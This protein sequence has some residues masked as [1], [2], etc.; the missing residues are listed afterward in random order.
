MLTGFAILLNVPDVSEYNSSMMLVS[1]A[2]TGVFGRGAI[3]PLAV[4]VFFFAYSTVICWYYYGRVATGYLFGKRG[5]KIFPPVYLSSVIIGVFSRD[6]L[7]ARLADTVLFAMTLPTLF[8]II[9][10]SDRIV[11]LSEREGFIKIKADVCESVSRR[12]RKQAFP[13]F[14]TLRGKR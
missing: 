6:I 1:D 2:M 10:S 14:R 8:C 3:L 11:A 4:S 9:K 7:S 13:K 5:E 12:R